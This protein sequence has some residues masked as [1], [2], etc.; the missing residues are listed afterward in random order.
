M[1]T[2]TCRARRRLAAT[3]C[4]ARRLGRRPPG[5]RGGVAA[6]PFRRVRPPPI[7]AGRAGVNG[8]GGWPHWPVRADT[9]ARRRGVWPARVAAGGG[10]ASPARSATRTRFV[11]RPEFRARS[12]A[13][14]LTAALPRTRSLS[15]APQSASPRGGGAPR[16]RR[17]EPP[18]RPPRLRAGPSRPGGVRRRD[19]PPQP[20]RDSDSRN[21]GWA[22]GP[23]APPRI[24]RLET[25]RPGPNRAPPPSRGA[26][27]PRQL[28]LRN[29]GR[30]RSGD[31]RHG[32]PGIRRAPGPA[33]RCGPRAVLASTD[34]FGGVGGRAG[35]RDSRPSRGGRGPIAGPSGRASVPRGHSSGHST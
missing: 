12:P 3:P 31:S 6:V 4:S 23:P 33:S 22:V 11:C 9:A 1:L 19:W 2:R 10:G 30:R 27:G 13:R 25:T 21:T 34:S 7:R 24:A 5:G 8:A 29:P 28:R 17:R 35:S 26:S 15:L 18:T 32:P 16:R 20:H 14:S